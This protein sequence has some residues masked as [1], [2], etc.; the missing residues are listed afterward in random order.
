MIL[1]ELGE[2]GAWSRVFNQPNVAKLTA[3]TVSGVDFP[4]LGVCQCWNDIDE[5]ALWVETY[6]A[7]HSKRG[8]AT[9]WR[10]SGL[11]DPAAVKNIMDEYEYTQWSVVSADAIKIRSTVDTHRFRITTGHRGDGVVV[12]SAVAQKPAVATR[13]T[14]DA[15][16]LAIASCSCC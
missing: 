7:T 12:P 10:V 5:A 13:S 1:S 16:A 2:P 6:S 9:T 4:T 15:G 8:Q 3:P 11:S 14:L